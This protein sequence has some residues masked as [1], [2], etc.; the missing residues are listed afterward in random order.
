MEQ[1][2]H[3]RLLRLLRP[4]HQHRPAP[5]GIR[6]PGP[7]LQVRRPRRLLVRR[8]RRSRRQARGGRGQVPRRHEAAGGCAA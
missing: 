3:L 1:L 8:P 6:P 2:E 5:D 4:P 7:R